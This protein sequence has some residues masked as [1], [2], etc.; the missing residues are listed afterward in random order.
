VAV[1]GAISRPAVTGLLSKKADYPAGSASRVGFMSS[2]VW[3]AIG[4][5]M[6]VW[7]SLHLAFPGFIH[8]I[9]WLTF[10]R[11]RPMHVQLVIYG[12]ISMAFVAAMYYIVPALCNN[13]LWSERLGYWQIWAW[14]VVLVIMELEWPIGLTTGIKYHEDIW[15]IS[16]LFAFVVWIPVMINIF[17]TTINRRVRGIYVS[18]WFF[19]ASLLMMAVS[20][21][22]GS[23][24]MGWTGL[25]EAYM[26]WW[27]AH[28]QL[29]LWIT[30]VSAAIAYYLVPKITGNVLYSHR[31]G[32]IHFW[33]I[34]AFYSTPGAHH[35][36]GA[37]IPEWI[38]S[39]ASVSG[40][41]ILIP[42]LAFVTNLL[43]TMRGKW[44]LFV[45]NPSVQWSI[46]GVLFAIPLNVQ[47]AFQQTRAINW[48][49]HGTHWIV[50]HA[51]LALL[52]FSTFI[53]VGAVYYA[54]PRL[55]GRKM[56]SVNMARWHFWLT[57]IGFMGFWTSLTAAGL[58]QAAGKVYQTPF[59]LVVEAIHPYMIGR[60]LFG[61]MVV[62]AQWLFLY[63]MVKTATEGEPVAVPARVP[64]GAVATAQP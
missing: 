43:M 33:S 13:K 20:W 15:P 47:G 60:S 31:I 49:I 4:T 38:K 18:I 54:L 2:V 59:I 1:S 53:E 24:L 41:L 26:N 22:L 57:A 62:V 37:P 42:A 32:H 11:V 44:H 29:G 39:Y 51:H 27:F 10:G 50:A 56:Y 64:P 5:T 52:G 45:E 23:D 58:V 7:T 9:P 12:W 8:D 17:L 46:T 25:N 16:I 34:V 35:L 55:L 63:N 19:C 40:V 30:P 61:A 48:Y 28:N 3:L 6:G 36:M 21:V 14:N